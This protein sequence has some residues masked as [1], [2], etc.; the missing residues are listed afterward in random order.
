MRLGAPG[1]LDSTTL[2][3]ALQ[4][5]GYRTAAF[6]ANH[7]F[8]T[9]NVGLGKGFIHFEDYF[10]SPEDMFVRTSLGCLGLAYVSDCG[11]SFKSGREVNHEA[12]QWIDKDQRPFLAVLNYIGVHESDA[13]RWE[14][15]HP[16]WGKIN[17]IDR[18]DSALAITDSVIGTLFKQLQVRGLASN[19]LLIVTS[20]HGQSLGQHHLI[21]HGSS[22]YL[23]QIHVPLIVWYPG[24]VPAAMRIARPVSNASISATIMKLIGSDNRLPG[25][26]LSTLWSGDSPSVYRPNPISEVAK[27]GCLDSHDMPA[28]SLVPTPLEGAMKSIITPRWHLIEHQTLG[29]QLYDWVND[30]GELT[31]LVDTR[32]GAE[33]ARDLELEMQT[34]KSP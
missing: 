34:D 19:T 26:D 9:S 2:G 3:E 1:L 10:Y 16:F 5:R 32:Q 11:F 6:S 12:L 17:E 28:R 30:P 20:D 14:R 24:R 18:Y 13:R 29:K 25:S 23:E 33:V 22:L 4:A 8:F 15:V 7:D 21:S 27:I 31:N